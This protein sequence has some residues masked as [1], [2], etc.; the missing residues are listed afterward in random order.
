VN[1]LEPERLWY[2]SRVPIPA[3]LASFIGKYGKGAGF[4]VAA[5]VG[6]ILTLRPGRFTTR[7]LALALLLIAGAELVRRAAPRVVAWVGVHRP[8]WLAGSGRW[9]PALTVAL[10]TLWLLGPVAIGQMPA[11][12]DHA[13]HYLATDILVRDLIGSGRLFGWTERLGAGYPY[14]DLYPTLSY[15]STGLAHLVSFRLIPLGVSYAFGI[16]IVWLLVSLGVSRIAQRLGNGWAAVFAGFWAAADPGADREG[17]W[18][19]AMFHGVWTQQLGVGLWL[20]AILAL[21]RLTERADTR[22]LALAGLL[23]GLTLLAHPLNSICLLI[24]G[25]LMVLVRLVGVR[26]QPARGALRLVPALALGGLIGLAWVVRMYTNGDKIQSIPVYWAP[27]PEIMGNALNLGPF[28]NLPAFISVFG[29]VGVAYA[30]YSRDLFAR[31]IVLLGGVLL[32]LGSME[33]VNALDLGLSGGTFRVLQYRRFSIPI[34]ALFLAL[35]GVGFWVVARGIRDAA[36]KAIDDGAGNALRALTAV[37]LAPAAFALLYALPYLHEAPSARPL[38]L[39]RAGELEHTRAILGVLKQE[40]QR[41]PAGALRRGVYIERPGTGGRYPTLALVDAGYGLL[42]NLF[43]PAQNFAALARTE[44]REVMHRLGASVLITRW[45]V[46]DPLLEPIAQHGGH[47]VYRFTKPPA[48]PVEV[49]GPGRADVIAWR[50]Q[51]KVLRLSGVRPETRL[52]LAMSPYSKWQAHQG[53]RAVPLGVR[54]V[55]GVQLISIQGAS[56]GELVIDYHDLKRETAAGWVGALSFLVCLIGVALRPRP[57]FTEPSPATLRRVYRA[58]GAACALFTLATVLWVW[59]RST[60]AEN[61][62]WLLGEPPGSTLGEVLHLGTPDK[63]TFT[64]ELFCVEEY[65]RDPGWGCTENQL[66]PVLAAGAV[67]T[68]RIP[69]CLLVGVPPLGKTMLS[70]RIPRGTAAIKGRLQNTGRGS[71]VGG[72]LLFSSGVATPLVLDRNFRNVPPAG[73]RSVF[74][75]LQNHSSMMSRVCLEAVTIDQPGSR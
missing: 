50:P 11:S 51:E 65:G 13:S 67:R 75:E 42:P 35:S 46:T 73:A 54:L 26:D 53:E 24:S 44:Q 64:P 74:I 33:L 9:L 25:G 47:T 18:G 52:T 55:Q 19:Y 4:G 56:D 16:C 8:A 43:I 1:L 14:G 57:L 32:A 63:L 60:Q 34:K 66:R 69:S 41:L 6:A 15:L 23:C 28:E 3:K 5:L 61:E 37:A 40:A 70:Y 7:W 21:W 27:L 48:P 45:P 49:E 17:G 30:L 72:T 59:R 20:F 62:E 31:Y 29:L 58:L 2:A 39:R 71:G 68:E 12:Q 10:L 22:R 38:T 36:R